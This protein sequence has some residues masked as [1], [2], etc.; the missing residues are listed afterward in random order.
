MSEKKRPSS[1]PRVLLISGDDTVASRLERELARTG[2]LQSQWHPGKDAPETP[3]GGFHVVLLDLDDP[4]QT[5]DFVAESVASVRRSSAGV[6]VFAVAQDPS[7]DDLLHLLEVGV[8]RFIRQPVDVFELAA[9][10]RDACHRSVLSRF[11]ASLV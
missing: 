5:Q 10:I 8:D 1:D 2:I 3:P 7:R 11:S 4:A 9:S 6:V